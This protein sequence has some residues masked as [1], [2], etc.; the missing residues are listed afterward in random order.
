MDVTVNMER[1]DLDTAQRTPHV[2]PSLVN[3]V[4]HHISHHTLS[5][6]V[7]NSHASAEPVVRVYPGKQPSGFNDG[8]I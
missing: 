4:P 5:L 2:M 7:V 1:L 3:I 6:A 8:S